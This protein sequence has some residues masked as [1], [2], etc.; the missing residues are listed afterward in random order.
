[1]GKTP[2]TLLCAKSRSSVPLACSITVH[3]SKAVR[4]CIFIV[5]TQ[6]QNAAS[7]S[8]AIRLKLVHY[9][10]SLHYTVPFGT[11]SN[12]QDDQNTEPP[13]FKHFSL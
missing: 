6:G 3:D 1:M 5:F 7:G 10:L 4:D 8:Y 11:S 12:V 2:F 13:K 9:I